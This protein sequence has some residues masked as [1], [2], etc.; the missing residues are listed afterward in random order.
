M[1]I[2][3]PQIG[4]GG[5]LDS[6]VPALPPKAHE[7][8]RTAFKAGRR[9][10]RRPSDRE[11]GRTPTK[12]Q[13][14]GGQLAVGHHL[15]CVRP[16][17]NHA[18][19]Q[20]QPRYAALGIPTFPFLATDG[21]K[22]PLVR[23]YGRIGLPA[24]RQLLMKGFDGD[25]LACMV[26]ERNKLTVIDVDAHVAEGERLLAD[27]QSDY[28]ESRFIVRTGSG[29]FHA[30][31]RH[32]GE[33]RRIRPDP[34]KPID[35]LGG[36]VVVLPPSRGALQHYEI[37]HGNLDDLACLTPIRRVIAPRIAPESRLAEP[38][39][40]GRRNDV[41]FG[42]CMNAAHHC[43]DLESLLDV[44]RTENAAMMPPMPDAEVMKVAT[45]AWSYTELGQNRCGRTGAWF[46]TAE[47]NTM[48]ASDQDA[49][50]LLAFLRANNGPK[51]TFMAANGLALTL[52]WTRKRLAGARQRLEQSH[53]TMVRPASE[54]NGAALYRWQPKARD[55]V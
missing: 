15:T 52:G 21:G 28:G 14:E 7:L 33:S 20:W 51:R 50:L 26:G 27:A 41:L 12:V 6:V 30:Y 38:V 22:R 13:P 44:A 11:R 16:T 40:I 48:I 8:S 31:Y 36:G 1:P 45:S 5:V 42:I 55:R 46:P 18:F 43:D 29:G 2:A 23:S 49:F 9:V 37:I 17:D 3:G 19:S 47:A 32:S 25:G 4:A 10:M 35:L 24:S 34:R 54:Q 39:G 53:I